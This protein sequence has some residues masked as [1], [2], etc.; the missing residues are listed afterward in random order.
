[1]PFSSDM[2]SQLPVA[3]VVPAPRPVTSQSATPVPATKPAVSEAEFDKLA[4]AAKNFEAYITSYVFSAA[5]E[6]LPQNEFSGSQAENM[7][8]SLFI[9]ETMTQQAKHG[10]GGGLAEMMLKQFR[11]AAGNGS[12]L[13]AE[14]TFVPTIP[15]AAIG[16]AVPNASGDV[17][18]AFPLAREAGPMEVTSGFGVRRDPFTGGH[19]EHHGVD[20]AVKPGSPIRASADGRVA[21]SGRN[22]GYGNAVI[23]DHGQGLETLYG[24]NASNVVREGQMIRRG[25]VVGYVGS[26]G[27]STGPHVHFEVRKDGVA[28]NPQK[29]LA[30]SDKV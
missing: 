9:N 8:Q 27:R 2:T 30:L 25:D 4:T 19:R 28:V 15:G 7:Y 10:G 18:L 17:S 14:Q 23:I 20:L 29:Y 3:A 24:H 1:M 22:G 21:F 13:S 16:A 6:S 26:T 12:A 5:Y 11:R